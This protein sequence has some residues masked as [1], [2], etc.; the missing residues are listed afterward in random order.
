VK[1][2]LA[3]ETQRNLSSNAQQVTADNINGKGYRFCK[4]E[5]FQ[6]ALDEGDRKLRPSQQHFGTMK[7]HGE[8]ED[9]DQEVQLTVCRGCGAVLDGQ[10]IQ[11][12]TSVFY[13]CRECNIS[14]KV[15]AKFTE[16]DAGY[17]DFDSVVKQ[18]GVPCPVKLN[19]PQTET[20][21]K[22]D[23]DWLIESK[24]WGIS[25]K[26]ETRGLVVSGKQR[27]QIY[28]ESVVPLSIT[29][30]SGIQVFLLKSLIVFFHFL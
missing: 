12:R 3:L 6:P 26:V 25:L 9:S 7:I 28:V 19:S 13:V 10:W 16:R 2:L 4:H 1:Y 20:C 27:M 24:A 23:T 30:L 21:S 29:A 14:F 11:S 22:V 15:D 18:T 8:N 17:A 5:Q